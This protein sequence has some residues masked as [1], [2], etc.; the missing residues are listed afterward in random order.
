MT[1][2]YLNASRKTIRR[3]YEEEWVKTRG[4]T[5]E[6]FRGHKVNR[7]WNDVPCSATEFDKKVADLCEE[8]LFR[9][10]TNPA[11][12]NSLDDKEKMRLLN[13]LEGNTTDEQFMREG[14]FADF[15]QVLAGKSLD[16]YK[17]ELQAKIH[18]VNTEISKNHTRL[19]E[20]KHGMPEEQDWTAIEAE[21]KECDKEITRLKDLQADVAKRS[22][23]KGRERAKIQDEINSENLKLQS[24][25]QTIRE[26][27]LSEHSAR[28]SK[29]QELL[30]RRDSLIS[31]IR[32]IERERDK[33][34]DERVELQQQLEKLTAE[35]K[36]IHA[37]TFTFDESEGIC[38]TCKQPLPY[39]DVEDKRRELQERFNA[40]RAKRLDANTKQGQSRAERLDEI[41]K[42]IKTLTKKVT[43]LST[44]VSKIEID[45]IVT[46]KVAAPD[47]QP[48]IDADPEIK[49]IQAKIETLREV[50]GYPAAAPQSNDYA[51]EEREWQTKKEDAQR[52][53]YV[54]GTIAEKR[55]RIA[56]I[57]TSI[58]QNG[59][60]LLN[61]E[62]DAN[63]IKEIQKAKALSV[64]ARI[65]SMFSL[66]RFNMVADQINGGDRQVCETTVGG[67]PY[68]SLNNAAR[69]NAGLDIIRAFSRH[70][71]VTAPVF[72]DNAEAVNQLT[73]MDCQMICL[74][75]TDDKVL[76]IK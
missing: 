36:A 33:A 32:G 43:E 71:G 10:I 7:F 52:R 40:S 25:R 37:D 57:E 75:V 5:E 48:V 66:V 68:A 55:N 58:R 60:A 3:E 26:E 20:V 13:T 49:A 19:D 14:G 39:D 45:P 61:L 24:R 54:R 42:E 38:P 18:N 64:E 16:E 56:E 21:I 27:V 63:T 9:L 65:N 11:H 46:D 53:L 50:L 73:D 62:R 4:E 51:A 41:E 31:Q 74:R 44:E 67:V 22:E 8:A 35:Y 47:P 12:F 34:C 1:N 70:F 30:R 59:Q 17:R 6:T 2:Q 15:L 28:E 23:E 29:R 69:I 72:V 76:T